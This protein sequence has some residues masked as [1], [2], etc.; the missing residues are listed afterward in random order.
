MD[1][2]IPVLGV[3]IA[4]VSAFV[5]GGLWY[6]PTMFLNQWMKIAGVTDKDMKKNMPKAMAIMAIGALVTSY[7]LAHFIVYAEKFTGT[8]GIAGGLETAFFV[9]LG[10]A[11]TTVVADSVF[12]TR[13]YMIVVINTTYRLVT[14]LAMGAIL[15]AFM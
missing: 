7:I 15:G 11:F 13:S 1:T 9:W 8:A 4:A 5:I 6:S 14:L 10:F 12:E 3:L 2:S